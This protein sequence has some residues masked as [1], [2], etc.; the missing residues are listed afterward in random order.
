MDGNGS[1]NTRENLR[2]VTHKENNSF[3]RLASEPRAANKL[4]VR[5]VVKRG[6][7]FGARI[8]EQWLGS[9]ATLEEAAAKYE[10]ERI[11]INHERT[12]QC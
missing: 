4:K 6:E 1:N 10:S 7:I 11:C 2:I 12:G 5:G 8:C 3:N 9:F